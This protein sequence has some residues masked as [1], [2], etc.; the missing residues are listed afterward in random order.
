MSLYKD[1]YLKYKQKYFRLKQ[2]KGGEIP[3]TLEN[4]ERKITY[5]ETH[6]IN[7][8][9]IFH[10]HRGECWSDSIQM[11]LCFGDEIKQSVQSKLF[12][13]NPKE[14][15]DMAYLSSRAKYLAPIY[16]RGPDSDLAQSLTSAK[17]EKR[18]IKY[19]G[20]LQ[21]RLC[22]HITD[23]NPD[24][25]I[26]QCRHI[27]REDEVCPLKETYGKFLVDEKGDEL[28]IGD[29]YQFFQD[30]SSKLTETQQQ[31][32]REKLVG[33][34][35][36]MEQYLT[37]VSEYLPKKFKLKKQ[38][39]EITG[40]GSAVQGLKLINK[41]APIEDNHG[42]SDDEQITIINILSF[43]LLDDD[44]VLTTKIVKP[45]QLTESDIEQSIGMKVSTPQHATSFFK[46]DG[47]EIYFNDNFG[48]VKL[49][50]KKLLKEYLKYS[51]THTLILYWSEGSYLNILK[52]NGFNNFIVWD[53]D[54][55]EV[56]RGDNISQ[57]E[58]WESKI[59]NGFII[60]KK[61]NLKSKTEDEIYAKLEEPFV[62]AD[63]FN[64]SVSNIKNLNMVIGG[65]N[66]IQSL[67]Y[68]LKYK[69]DKNNFNKVLSKIDFSVISQ[70]D[71]DD[72][73]THIL[74]KGE[75]DDIDINCLE[76]LI[77]NGATVMA[78]N[79]RDG[80]FYTIIV[81]NTIS[82][83]Q[84][85][86]LEIILANG[87]DINQFNTLE[88]AI[89]RKNLDLVSFLVSHG[90]DV[91]NNN[92]YGNS[93]LFTLIVYI[94]DKD[95]PFYY[96]ALEILIEAGANLNVKKSDTSLLEAVLGK[97]NKKV[98]LELLIKSGIDLN[99]K[100]YDGDYPIINLVDYNYRGKN[101]E[102]IKIFISHDAE[103]NIKSKSGKPLLEFVIKGEN[104][105][106][107]NMIVS[108]GINIDE[109]FA[110]GDIPIA[111]LLSEWSYNDTK[112]QMAQLLINSGANI[113]SSPKSLLKSSI[114]LK[115]VEIT[116]LLI[117]KGADPNA[118]INKSDTPLFYILDKYSI[119]TSDVCI[120]KMLIKAGINVNQLNKDGESGLILLVRNCG[121]DPNKIEIIDLLLKAGADPTAKD[122]YG[123][124]IFSMLKYS[125]DGLKE[126]FDNYFAT[127]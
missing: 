18:L 41:K 100:L 117:N 84:Y 60:V 89:D 63:I 125:S 65:N 102:L 72:L 90:A 73:A 112:K 101:D 74:R 42:A 95:T 3:E 38:L 76:R 16:R 103:L 113:N 50:W 46:C 10:Q 39:S 48:K 24:R 108:K 52:P 94:E 27:I 33:R 56:G 86:L 109:P 126:Y 58:R 96:R 29:P 92:S 77:A 79:Y 22:L 120:V 81:G 40:I 85:K 53:L 44:N 106:I 91:N 47:D 98:L 127:K 97:P 93:L 99:Q 114:D 25:D 123:N 20:L 8:G 119:T 2:Q 43:A 59:V 45:W 104:I 115:D 78:S 67:I 6:C 30:I 71:K 116:Q 82:K 66:I 14:I 62:M 87:Q 124:D 110:N 107:L 5:G 75:L 118:L 17:F 88:I 31:E 105:D 11:L 37:I 70:R 12:N 21:S 1:K 9:D 64:C 26:P 19:L 69:C 122:K 121:G 111:Y 61:E 23:R 4:L 7:P 54:A 83:L 15:I 51:G 13:L 55:N 49:Q 80:M 32:L 36:T 68:N 35:L 34:P 57:F 28:T